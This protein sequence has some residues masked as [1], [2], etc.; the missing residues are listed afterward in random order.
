MSEQKDIWKE[1]GAARDSSLA[2]PLVQT[3]YVQHRSTQLLVDG[4]KTE[5]PS[6]ILPEWVC[7]LLR[8][9]LG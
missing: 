6:L 3:K 7:V 8:V 9:P 1:Q 2:H 5:P 4:S